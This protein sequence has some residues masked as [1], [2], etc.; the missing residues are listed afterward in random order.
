MAVY[1]GKID[2]AEDIPYNKA[3]EFHAKIHDSLEVDKAPEQPSRKMLIMDLF[4][5][6]SERLVRMD[7]EGASRVID[8]LK[9]FLQDYDS[10]KGAFPVIEEYTEF[11]IINVG[12]WIME[13]CM[14]WTLDIC[15]P[16]NKKSAMN[17]VSPLD[18]QWVL[19]TTYTPGMSNATTPPTY[20]L[21]EEDAVVYLKGLIMQH[22][23]K[24]RQLGANVRRQCA[25][26][27]KME[28]LM[29][30]LWSAIIDQ[31]LFCRQNIPSTSCES[32]ACGELEMPPEMFKQ[33]SRSPSRNPS[34]TKP[35]R[36]QALEDDDGVIIAAELGWGD[37]AND[38]VGNDLKGQ[39]AAALR[40]DDA[41]GPY[42]HGRKR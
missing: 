28:N 20:G 9:S 25:G 7:E 22:E 31:Y 4:H 19:P 35:P 27:R 21:T 29:S 23:Q 38:E 10:K 32:T 30:S 39:G 17:S 24:T 3:A 11:R 40:A 13:S 36:L 26:L 16:P 41:S 42:Q 14:Q 5:E 34:P 18:V 2:L 1:D 6:F 12:F 15:L 8:S 33:F 37:E